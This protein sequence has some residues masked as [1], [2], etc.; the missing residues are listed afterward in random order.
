[1]FKVTDNVQKNCPTLSVNHQTFICL[2]QLKDL[3][4]KIKALKHLP[5][6][7]VKSIA[8]VKLI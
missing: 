1:M 7:A 3:T 6:D 4:D 8:T 2:T 5:F